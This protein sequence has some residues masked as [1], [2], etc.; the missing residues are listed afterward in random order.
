MSRRSFLA[1]VGGSV[2]V[3]DST[4][5]LFESVVAPVGEVPTEDD[6]R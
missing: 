4:G 2:Y 6:A 5:D 1:R 3:T